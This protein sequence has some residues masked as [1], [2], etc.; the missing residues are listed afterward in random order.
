VEK[1]TDKMKKDWVG[2]PKGLVRVTPGRW[3]FTAAYTKFADK[4]YNFKFKQ[5]DVVVNTW[6]KCG[7]TWVQEIV[8]TMT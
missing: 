3:L 8:W 4:Y 2:Y 1:E 7:T 5:S 6:P